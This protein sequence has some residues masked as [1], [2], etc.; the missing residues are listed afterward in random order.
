CETLDWDAAGDFDLVWNFHNVLGFVD[1]PPL[2]IESAAG[3]LRPGGRLVSF[4]PNLHHAA[5]FNLSLGNLDGAMRA[6][7]QRRGRFTADM[8]EIALFTASQLAGWYE[9]SGLIV[10][11]VRGFPG[12]IY[13]GYAET[14]IAGQSNRLTDLLG[15]PVTYAGIF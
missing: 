10:E 5:F 12:L 13:P 11:V 15:N 9:Q 4:A 1:N 6:V 8:P 2:L 7:E 3:A 14:Q